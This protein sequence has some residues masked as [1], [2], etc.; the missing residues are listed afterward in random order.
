MMM[1]NATAGPEDIL[2][3]QK[4][5]GK[6]ERERGRMNVLEINL[7]SKQFLIRM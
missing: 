6:R 2:V 1:K 5:R 4:N 3:V 7:G